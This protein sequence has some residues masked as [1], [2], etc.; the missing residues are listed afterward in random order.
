MTSAARQHGAAFLIFIFLLSL[1]ALGVF[2]S[3]LNAQTQRLENDKRTADA[4]AKAMS[5][6]TGYAVSDSNRPGELPCP[7]QNNDGRLTAADLLGSNCRAL[8]GRLPLRV[9]NLPDLRDG[10]GD[11]L[12]YALSNNF[13]ANGSTRI[14]ADT[15]GAL[16]ITGNTTVGSVVAVVFSP[17]KPLDT[18]NRGGV[19]ANNVVNFLEGENADADSVYVQALESAGFNDRLVFISS[20]TLLSAVGKRV[21]NE[22]RVA[23]ENFKEDFGYFPYATTFQNPNTSD[24]KSDPGVMAGHL[25]AE[26]SNLEDLLPSWI[27]GQRWHWGIYYAV[28]PDFVQG[29]TQTCGGGC[30]TLLSTAT[31]NNDKPAVVI[32]TGA[33]LNGQTHPSASTADYLEDPE[34]L[35]GNN[36]FTA[37]PVNS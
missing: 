4:L 28:A 32:L 24:F 5:A 25:P 17:G 30:L 13:H 9:L 10:N 2:F 20:A 23:L 35:D 11:R 1:A 29:A 26:D 15:V 6:L 34:N 18:Q 22:T 21:L 19:G 27:E 31:P 14:N 7:D 12:W 3:G 36:V 37:R 8:V 16:T 33:A